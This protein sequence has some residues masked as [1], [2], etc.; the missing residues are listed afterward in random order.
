MMVMRDWRGGRHGAIRAFTHP[1]AV[2]MFLALVGCSGAEAQ[3]D[4][5]RAGLKRQQVALHRPQH[6]RA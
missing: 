5:C 6:H 1:A 3:S 4:E 2:A